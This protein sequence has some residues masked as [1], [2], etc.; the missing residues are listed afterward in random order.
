MSILSGTYCLN[1]YIYM[2]V[3]MSY[4]FVVYTC[5][6]IQLFPKLLTY[7]N[8]LIYKQI[9]P[10][11]IIYEYISLYDRMEEHWFWGQIVL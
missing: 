1:V 5:Y 3:V 9:K 10:E 2:C 8:S 7:L 4:W 6:A 11:S